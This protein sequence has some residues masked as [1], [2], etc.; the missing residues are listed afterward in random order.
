MHPG[1]YFSMVYLE[2]TGLNQ[3]EAAEH[4]RISTSAMSRLISGASDLSPEMAVRL[5]T[6]FGRSAESWMDMQTKFSLN[7]AREFVQSEKLMPFSNKE[8]AIA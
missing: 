6:V 4:L 5:E 2:P 3:R 8:L 1:E 7:K